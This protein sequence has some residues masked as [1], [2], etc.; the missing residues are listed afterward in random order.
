MGKAYLPPECFATEEALESFIAKNTDNRQ[1]LIAEPLV[2]L[3][4]DND[5][6]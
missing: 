2:K 3:V 5:G 4:L 6:F 1:R